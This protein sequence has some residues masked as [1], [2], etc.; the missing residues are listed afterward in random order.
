MSASST[1]RGT[2]DIHE[3]VVNAATHCFRRWGLRKTTMGD[4]AD[5]AG[6]LRPHLYRYFDSK[7]A[8]IAK[9]IVREA[10]DLSRNRS[11]S[12]TL[13]GPVAPLIV[14]VLTAGHRA[15][16]ADEFLGQVLVGDGA[17]LM[18]RLLTDNPDFIEAQ[19]TFWGPTFRYGRE[20]AEIR[21]DLSDAEIISWF[22][23]SQMTLARHS[24]Y[25]ADEVAVQT[26]LERFVVPAIL[27]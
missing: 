26:H 5:E 24:E 1:E 9:A 3:R 16:V 27:V 6:M 14:D 20:R 11:R 15:M 4:I 17:D 21:S 10:Q 2:T 7:E 13:N 18:L 8:L 19:T 25:F 12:F 23:I 22:L